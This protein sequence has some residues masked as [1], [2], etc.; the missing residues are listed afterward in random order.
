MTTSPQWSGS[1]G[2]DADVEFDLLVDESAPTGAD[3]WAPLGADPADADS[4]WSPDSDVLA[5]SSGPSEHTGSTRAPA[6]E[7]VAAAGT[8]GRAVIAS[9]LMATAAAAVLDLALVGRLSFFF[10]VSFVVICLVA[11]MA[12]R[13]R[14]LF[15]AA[16]LPPLIFG[17]AICGVALIWPQAILAGAGLSTTFLTGLAAH[18]W[19]LVGGYAAALLTVAAR[20][21]ARRL[22]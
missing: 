14:D 1:V 21:Y 3:A 13:S 7:Y 2:S 4:G 17:V 16:V 15:T 9:T 8:P 19:G 18:A 11:A 22:T 6:T 12:V 10:D 20:A 5:G